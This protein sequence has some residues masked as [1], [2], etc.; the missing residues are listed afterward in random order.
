MSVEDPNILRRIKS[1]EERLDKLEDRVSFIEN[2]LGSFPPGPAPQPRPIT[3]PGPSP[4]HPPDPFRIK[5]E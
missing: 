1:I 2:R 5:K 3:P 4:G